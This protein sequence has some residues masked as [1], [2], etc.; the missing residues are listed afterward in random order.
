MVYFL[1][2]ISFVCLLKLVLHNSKPQNQMCDSNQKLF[3]FYFA[4]IL[5]QAS[6]WPKHLSLRFLYI[7]GWS[8]PPC[9]I[10]WCA[11]APA[12]YPNGIQFK[13]ICQ[14]CTFYGFESFLKSLLLSLTN[15]WLFSGFRGKPLTIWY[16]LLYHSNQYSN[17]YPYLI[18]KTISTYVYIM[19]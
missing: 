7:L 18:I 4:K 1:S 9:G 10:T 14:L 15:F 19:V 16:L 11:F 8:G 6:T 2:Y 12:L 17:M 3:L 5:N 13:I